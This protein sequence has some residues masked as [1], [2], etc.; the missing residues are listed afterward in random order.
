MQNPDI[1]PVDIT[2]TSPVPVCVSITANESTG[3]SMAQA[4]LKTFTALGVYAVHATTADVAASFTRTVSTTPVTEGFLR[5]QLSAIS[6]SMPI[7]GVKVGMV[8]SAGLIRVVGRWLREHPMV[9][10]VVDPV[11]TDQVGIPQTQPE[12]VAAMKQELLPRATLITP[13]RFEAAQLAGMDEVLDKDDMEIAAKK[14]FDVHGCGVVVTGG[15]MGDQSLDVFVGM[16]G[17]SHF[18]LP[19]VVNEHNARVIGAGCTYA[20]AIVAQ[21]SR[22]ESIR[23]SLMGAKHYVRELITYSPPIAFGESPVQPIYHCLAVSSLAQA[24]GV[25]IRGR[26]I[27]NRNLFG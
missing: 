7:N 2:P 14:L 15:G 12:V 17:T 13:N 21:L 22:R 18:E 9:P 1:T 19:R 24:E 27:I 5:D 3:C 6:E 23:D 20:A 16:D 10:V 8:P 26:D 4:D 25:G 11:L